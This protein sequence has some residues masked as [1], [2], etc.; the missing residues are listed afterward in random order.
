VFFLFVA[1]FLSGLM[2][3]TKFTGG[4]FFGGLFL[5][6]LCYKRKFKAAFFFALIFFLVSSVFFVSHLSVPIEPISVGSYGKLVSDSLLKQI[7]SNV[8][9][10]IEILSFF[11]LRKFYVFFVP[12][13]FV[14]GLFWRQRAEADFFA[15]FF[16]SLV[17]FMF[18]FA[19]N[20][21][22]PTQ[23]GFPRYFLPIYAL[24]CV[25]SG[26]Q[27]KKIVLL[28][29][30]RVV[31]FFSVLFV[32]FILFNS[33]PFLKIFDKEQNRLNDVA[34]LG[35]IED[36][37]DISVWFVDSGALK[38]RLIK[39]VLYDYVWRADFSGEPCAFL[40]KHKIDYVLYFN[41][42][43]SPNYLGDFGPKL[44]N[45]LIEGD[46]AELISKSDSLNN[47]FIFKIIHEK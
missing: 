35:Q 5:F 11:F 25:F 14:L 10:V 26:I 44:R 19:I 8:L 20:N 32:L 29:Y 47:A 41:Y 16:I 34:Y 31:A 46:C 9:E 42:S 39:A 45:S 15:L 23:T 24:L 18:F 40:R 6:L 13:L 12:F 4:I 38:L 2:F 30:K 36:K 43:D 21:A 33:L 22:S 27:L 37:R 3:L 7:P 17:F 1:G 28:K